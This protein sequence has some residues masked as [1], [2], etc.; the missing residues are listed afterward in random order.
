MVSIVNLQF[1]ST[2]MGAFMG[3]RSVAAV[4]Q[5]NVL[6]SMPRKGA[7]AR[8]A[9]TRASGPPQHRSEVNQAQFATE[10]PIIPGQWIAQGQAAGCVME[11]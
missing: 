2:L 9:S 7:A 10:R 3:C 1:M 6:I 11:R 4:Q 8:D 5:L